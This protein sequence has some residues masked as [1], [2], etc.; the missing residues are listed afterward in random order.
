[1]SESSRLA[2]TEPSP[3]PAPP[4]PAQNV[5]AQDTP[6]QPPRGH[7]RGF[8]LWLGPVIGVGVIA[9]I[10][11]TGGRVVTVTDSNTAARTVLIAPQVSGEV[12]SRAVVEGQIVK[13]GD[14]LFTI[15]PTAYAIAVDAAKA[16]LDAARDQIGVLK[17]NYEV[18]ISAVRSAKATYDLAV[19][20][21]ERA[22]DLYR[23]NAGTAAQRDQAAAD[24]EVAVAALAQARS[25]QDAALAQLG[26]D[27]ARPVDDQ[28]PV[29]Q[30]AQT[31]RNAERNLRLTRV[32]APFEG[33]LANVDSLQVGQE[34]AIGAATMGLVGVERAWIVANIKETDL[35]GIAV[36]HTARVTIDAFPDL[37]WK[38]KVTTI[39]AATGATF[40]ILPAQNT[41]G[42]WVKVVQRVPVRIDLEPNAAAPA[43]S[44]GLSATAAVDTGRVRSLR[45]LLA[46]VGLS[47]GPQR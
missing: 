41:S 10:Y 2:M 6:A 38:G 7:M 29:R 32:T 3:P 4:S 26:G 15:D 22:Q 1:M 18:K 5:P 24:L 21:N 28:P 44:A 27:A 47:Q 20:T 14:L 45:S 17:S 33:K 12:V 13:A 35:D 31:L 43:I 19:V 46:L 42:N 37:V 8:L 11:F 16:Q 25:N 40:A 30:A 36:G 34:L 23:K 9:W 39:G